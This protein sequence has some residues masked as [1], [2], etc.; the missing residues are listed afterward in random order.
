MVD[1]VVRSIDAILSMQGRESELWQPVLE[2]VPM[3]GVSISTL[4]MFLGTET[5]AASDDIA[6]RVDE[7]QF[8]L[9][10]GP[11]WDAFRSG[12]PVHEPN[13]PEPALNRWPALAEAMQNEL[14]SALFAF[15][16]TFGSLDL[17]AMDLYAR[18]PGEMGAEDVE[19]ASR[20]ADAIARVV[21]AQ[22]LAASDEPES[23]IVSGQFSRRVVH[24]A[25]GYVIAQLGLSPE[26]ALLL[27]HA[28]A[29]A[30]TRP[31]VEVAA[32]IV[33]RRLTFGTNAGKI[34]TTDE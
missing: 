24:Q 5:V 6:A 34:G 16:L 3:D 14:V 30:S 22:A 19:V 2:R 32:D 27:I 4:A 28:H 31:V 33:E 18:R 12:R 17:G 8:D 10:E 13:L 11:C 20:L 7:A 29:F 15:P 1:E 21:I 9:G 26:D 25:T 23:Q